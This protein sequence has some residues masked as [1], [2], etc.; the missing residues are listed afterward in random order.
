M[1]IEHKWMES[2]LCGFLGEGMH[3]SCVFVSGF[4]TKQNKKK[5]MHF[6]EFWANII[7]RPLT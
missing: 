6:F 1:S 2:A 4:E 7:H 3:G 5:P